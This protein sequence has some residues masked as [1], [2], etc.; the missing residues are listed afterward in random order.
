[1]LLKYLAAA[2]ATAA[3][4]AAAA[5]A[6]AAAAAAPT[7]SAALTAAAA[8]RA[9]S[10]ATFPEYFGHLI[11]HSLNSSGRITL[12]LVI[13]IMAVH[14][15]LA[16]TTSLLLPRSRSEFKNV[17][18]FHAAVFLHCFFNVLQPFAHYTIRSDKKIDAFPEIYY[19][20]KNDLL[21]VSLPFGRSRIFFR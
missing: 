4:T 1:M 9:P 6:T 18:E 15:V 5:L 3:A 21:P 13:V 12:R 16:T 19:N 2:S 8:A 11:E 7:S 20:S 14:A 10:A 17:L